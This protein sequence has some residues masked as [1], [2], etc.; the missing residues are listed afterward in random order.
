MEAKTLEQKLNDLENAVKRQQHDLEDTIKRQQREIETL[1]A[2]HEIQNLMSRYEYLKMVSRHTEIAKMFA[3]KTPGVAA[4]QELW[5]NWEGNE[6]IQRFYGK[7]G[8]NDFRDKQD[9]RGSLGIHIT[10][11]AVIEVA[12]DGKTAKGVWVSYGFHT[13]RTPD[14][15]FDIGYAWYKFGVDFVKEDGQWKFWHFRLS[16]V[17]HH[18]FDKS[19]VEKPWSPPYLEE[20]PPEHKEDT[21]ATEWYGWAP[22][23]AP[24]NHP[25]PPEPYETFDEKTAY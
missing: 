25:A 7:G 22:H 23:L 6:G 17:V 5:G 20:R 9:K 11:S 19:W 21:P 8:L 2:V 3:T 12:G 1:K 15:K 4:H 10:A 13:R 18:T 24:T 14:A 16:P